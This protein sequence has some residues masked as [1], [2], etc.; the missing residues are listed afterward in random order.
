MSALVAKELQEQNKILKE[1][2][3]GAYIDKIYPVGSIYMSVNNISP[4][5][6]IGGTW[7]RIKDRFLL[8]A[9]DAYAA[10]AEGGSKNHK[11]G[12]SGL[13]AAISP[14]RNDGNGEFLTLRSISAPNNDENARNRLFKGAITYEDISSNVLGS[15]NGTAVGGSTDSASNMPPYLAVYM[16]KRT[17]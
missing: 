15:G 17:A 8:S 4:Q 11:H 2:L 12:A 5:S 6:F 1:L 3:N 10:G 9:G 7:E 16:W 13:Y 14:K